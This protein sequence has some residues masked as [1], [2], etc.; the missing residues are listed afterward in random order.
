MHC[1]TSP[2]DQIEENV[3]CK[4]YLRKTRWL[5]IYRCQEDKL[6]SKHIEHT[7]YLSVQK[8]RMLLVC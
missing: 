5:E 3:S 1:R 6:T 7:H 4:A 8:M 2:L